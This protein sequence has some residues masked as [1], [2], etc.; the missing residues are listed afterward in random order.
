[1]QMNDGMQLMCS[2]CVRAQCKAHACG[3]R[4]NYSTLFHG[5]AST[6]LQRTYVFPPVALTGGSI[7][8]RVHGGGHVGGGN[9]LQ[10]DLIPRAQA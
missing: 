10:L 4:T 1:M 7:T 3:V 9:A 2:C 6:L 8:S 5:Y